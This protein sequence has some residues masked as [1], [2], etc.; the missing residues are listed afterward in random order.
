MSSVNY[1][2]PNI[3]LSVRVFDNFY[4]YETNVPAQEYD[5]VYSYFLREM[6]NA[7]YAG[8]FAVSLFRIAEQTG[9]P[10]LTLLQQFQNEGQAQV[11]MTLD[12]QMAY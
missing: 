4:K 11:G 1:T 12:I 6:G 10:A 3:D 9:I 7:N 5:V 2:N 8:N